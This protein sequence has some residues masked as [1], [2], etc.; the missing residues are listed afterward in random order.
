MD[1]TLLVLLIGLASGCAHL[2]PLSPL[3]LDDATGV[4]MRC[5]Q[6]FPAQPWRATHTIFAS[7]PFGQNGAL[8]G[9]TAAGSDGLHAVLLSPEGICLFD[10][11]QDGRTS[12]LTVHRAVP[13]FDRPAFA[14]SLM[15]D[16]GHAYLPPAG[17]PTA[18]G[19]YATGETVCRWSQAGETTDVVL[20]ADGPRTVSTYR[21]VRLT[22]E[23]DLLGSAAD[24]FFPAVHLRVPGVGGYELDIRL[25]DHE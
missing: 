13:P 7:L 17:E 15:S 12:G 8:V 11:N 19:T 4:A 1:R 2:P 21:E 18:I 24:G 22:R 20:R 14:A 25:V 16:V 6:A 23:I 3:V 10:A 5:R 9:V